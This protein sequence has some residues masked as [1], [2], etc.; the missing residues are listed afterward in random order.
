MDSLVFEQFIIGLTQTPLS[1]PELAQLRACIGTIH[2]P[3]ECIAL[4]EQAALGR[5]CPRCGGLRAH[6]CG[7]A[8]GLQRYRCLGCRR[9]YNALTGTPLARLRKKEHWLDGLSAMRARF[10]D[11]ARG[12]RRG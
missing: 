12:C 3:G 5:G 6:R 9:S 11:R 8:S 1:W 7:H 2:D 4:I 10:P